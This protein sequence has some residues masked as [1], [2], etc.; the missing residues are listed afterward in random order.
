MRERVGTD[1]IGYSENRKCPRE[2]DQTAACAGTRIMKQEERKRREKNYKERRANRWYQ[3]EGC[4]SGRC[5]E[6]EARN[7]DRDEGV[8]DAKVQEGVRTLCGGA[9]EAVKSSDIQ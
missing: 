9:G 1:E 4:S 2:S 6:N 8:R 3:S 7:E 5:G